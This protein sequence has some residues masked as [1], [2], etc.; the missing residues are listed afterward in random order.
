MARE[1]IQAFWEHKGV[2]AA[3]E[4]PSSLPAL[5]ES[6]PTS[7]SESPNDWATEREYLNFMATGPY[8]EEL[9]EWVL[10]A[11]EWDFAPE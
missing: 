1:E 2:V 11:E 6:P 3:R 9:L 8:D 5:S 10:H 7:S 4:G